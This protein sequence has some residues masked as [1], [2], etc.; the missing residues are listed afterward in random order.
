MSD[1]N[2]HFLADGISHVW[3]NCAT[4]TATVTD[5]L[6]ANW[7]VIVGWNGAFNRA[8][9]AGCCMRPSKSPIRT[10]HCKCDF[11]VFQRNYILNRNSSGEFGIFSRIYDAIQRIIQ[12][13]RIMFLQYVSFLSGFIAFCIHNG[14]NICGIFNDKKTFAEG[15]RGFR[16]HRFV[17]A[18]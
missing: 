2:T 18:Y 1:D 15:E 10:G 17:Y 14:V 16:Q 11:H 12:L 13:C 6:H 3:I 7:S 5:R 4:K 8:R 9:P